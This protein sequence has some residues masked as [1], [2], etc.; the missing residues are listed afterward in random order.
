MEKI[1]SYCVVASY[2][3]VAPRGLLKAGAEGS[4]IALLIQSVDRTLQMYFKP[5]S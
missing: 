5:S 4:S 1:F 3:P 2:T